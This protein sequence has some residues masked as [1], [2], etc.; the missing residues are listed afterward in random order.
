ML[1]PKD[2]DKIL[3]W[4]NMLKKSLGSVGWD[5]FKLFFESLFEHV[6]ILTQLPVKV[7]VTQ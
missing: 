1:R 2:K 4:C 3:Y 6:E 7:P 5:F